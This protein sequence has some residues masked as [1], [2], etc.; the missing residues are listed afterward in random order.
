M[1]E[2]ARTVD[3]G[4]VEMSK[5][6]FV[7]SETKSTNFLH[8]TW[9][10]VQLKTPSTDCRYFYS[11]QRY[12]RSKSKVVQKRAH[13]RFLARSKWANTIS[14]LVDLSST[15][16]KTVVYNAVHRL[17]IS[18]SDPKIFAVKSKV[19]L[20]RF[21]FWTV[22]AFPNFKGAVPPP[23]FCTR[24][25]TPTSSTSRGKVSIRLISLASKF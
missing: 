8:L 12:S 25:N 20:Y 22:F 21:E 23:K 19:A 3:V 24:V 5:H 14:W 2:K 13:C 11:F 9:N 4:E 18:L 15:Q 6:N 17:S 1:S 10:R 7:V 16:K